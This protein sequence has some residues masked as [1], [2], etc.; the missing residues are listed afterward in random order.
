MYDPA[1]YTAPHWLATRDRR[2]AKAGHRCEHARVVDE[3][4]RLGGHPYRHAVEIRCP[5]TSRLQVHHL[6][7]NTVGREADDDLM[8]LCNRHHILAHLG[9]KACRRCGEPVFDAEVDAIDF[10]DGADLT[11][12]GALA[13]LLDLAPSFCGYCD[14]VL[15]N[16]D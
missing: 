2:L 7:Y 11:E 14:H 8:V 9:A 16:D 6:H 5:E 4:A 3:G 13:S 15:G 12:D 1:Y 10:S